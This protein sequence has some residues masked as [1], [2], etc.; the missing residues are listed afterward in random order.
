MPMYDRVR[1]REMREEKATPVS[2]LLRQRRAV[3]GGER[4]AGL[5]MRGL[6]RGQ[7]MRAMRRIDLPQWRRLSAIQ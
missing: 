1:R 5:R 4:A 6:I 2:K 7:A 3:P